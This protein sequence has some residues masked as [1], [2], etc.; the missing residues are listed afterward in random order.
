MRQC[1]VLL[2]ITAKATLSEKMVW[3]VFK[4]GTLETGHIREVV[5]RLHDIIGT[6]GG[7]TDFI[8][9]LIV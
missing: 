6:L 3:S 5:R 8:D 9:T 2:S 7:D 1:H 4:N